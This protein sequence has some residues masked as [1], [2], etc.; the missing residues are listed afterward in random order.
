MQRLCGAAR[1]FA[2]RIHFDHRFAGARR[3]GG[4]WRICGGNFYRCGCSRY[5]GCDSL[6]RGGYDRHRS[7]IGHNPPRFAGAVI[8]GPLGAGLIIARLIVAGLV[9]TRLVIACLI[10]TL[11]IAALLIAALLIVSR[12]VIA[13]GLI[14]AGLVIALLIARAVIRPIV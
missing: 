10:A 8:A 13:A 6:N 4:F 9:T 5:W 12:A 3:A 1:A 7:V 11:L 2:V 14:A